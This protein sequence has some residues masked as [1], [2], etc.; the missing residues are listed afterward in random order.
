MF[1]LE[2]FDEFLEVHS[3]TLV[4]CLLKRMVPMLRKSVLEDAE[5]AL[6]GGDAAPASGDVAPPD[7]AA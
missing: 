5:M 1:M 3:V 7:A 4:H 2:Q 6:A